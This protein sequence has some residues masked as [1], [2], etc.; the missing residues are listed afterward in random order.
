MKQIVLTFFFL[1]SVAV[2]ANSQNITDEDRRGFDDLTPIKIDVDGDGI[3][4]TIQPRIYQITAKPGI[5][6]KRLRKRDIQN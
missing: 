3:A 2:V 1:L 4:D 6:G 5:K